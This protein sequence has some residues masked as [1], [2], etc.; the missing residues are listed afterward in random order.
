VTILLA[1]V[2]GGALGYVLARGDFC[3]HSTW[4]G[5]LDSP[6][7]A[8]LLRAYLL[9]LL[10]ATPVV[11][12]MRALGWIEPSIPSFA[13]RAA[14]VGGLVFGVGMV[15]AS[16]CIT[17]FFYKLGHGMVGAAVGIG[18]WAAGDVVTYR[19][20][21]SGWR[22][23][24]NADP[25]TVDGAAATATNWGGAGGL[26]LVVLIGAGIAVF[27]WRSRRRDRGK[28]WS[29]VVLGSAAAMVTS[30][31]WLLAE[32]HGTDYTFGTSS[33]PTAVWD[34]LTGGG[35]GSR[36]LLVGLLSIIPGSFLAASRVGT[37]WV[38]GET[39]RRYAQLAAGG[40]VMGVGAAVA[41]GCNLG[42]SM[43]GVPLLS[44]ASITTTVAMV[45]GVVIA[46]RVVKIRPGRRPRDRS[47]QRSS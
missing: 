39:S 37:L 27:L 19:G 33:L 41:G 22:D 17:G 7:S 42:H 44:L 1:V 3:F 25:T 36:W 9:L 24:L 10:I 30:V 21:L 31:A 11:S 20:P 47:L 13:W 34:W 38:R 5:L 6:P 26:V 28:L 43:V 8:D 15:I 40:F 45:G 18:A 14:V 23:D 46:D 32:V 2:A 29:W 16:S 12:A 4:R 35:L